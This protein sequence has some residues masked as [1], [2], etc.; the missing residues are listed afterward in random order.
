MNIFFWKDTMDVIFMVKGELYLYEQRDLSYR[1]QYSII[2]EQQNFYKD[3]N[4]YLKCV[5]RICLQN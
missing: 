2:L 5:R 1:V 4:P 3:L